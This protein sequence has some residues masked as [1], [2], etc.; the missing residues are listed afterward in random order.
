[1]VPSD[2]L[3]EADF[4]SPESHGSAQQP[5]SKVYYEEPC[6]GQDVLNLARS[7]FDLKEYR[8]CAHILQPMIDASS[9]TS[10]AEQ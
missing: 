6:S 5:F 2:C 4:A 1:M 3:S 10:S 7:L 9:V 8:K